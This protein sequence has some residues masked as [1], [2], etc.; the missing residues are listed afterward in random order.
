VKFAEDSFP[1]WFA[2]QGTGGGHA[3]RGDLAAR[4]RKL[5]NDGCDDPI[6]RFLTAHFE[7]AAGSSKAAAAGEFRQALGQLEKQTNYPRAVT[8]LVA[9]YLFGALD[10]PE[11]ALDKKTLGWTRAAL[12]EG[13]CDG[14]DDALFVEDAFAG[15]ALLDRNC[16]SM[17]DIVND[18]KNLP[19]RARRTILGRIE[20]RRARHAR[21]AA[22]DTVNEESSKGFGPGLDA[23]RDE[24]LSAWKLRPDQ[25][26]AATEMIKVVA[27]GAA[28]PRES[29]RLWFDRAVKA[30]FDYMPAYSAYLW[31]LRQ[32]WG[33]GNEEIL[34]FGHACAATKRYDTGVPHF[35]F[36]VIDDIGDGDDGRGTYSIPSVADDVIAVHKGTIAT[37]RPG[38]DLNYCISNLVLDAWACRRFDEALKALGQLPNRT[39]H[40]SITDRFAQFRTTRMIVLGEIPV[41]NSPAKD[42]YTKGRELEKS[43]RYP[44]AIGK[45]AAAQRKCGGDPD[46]TKMLEY[47]V[48]KDTTRVEFEKGQWMDISPRTRDYSDWALSP[49]AEWTVPEDGVLQFTGRDSTAISDW[50][51][52]VGENYEVRA[53][54]EFMNPPNTPRNF[55]I[56]LGFSFAQPNQTVTCQFWAA[57]PPKAELMVLGNGFYDFEN[58]KHQ[59]RLET[60]NDLHVKCWQGR[61]S[62]YL[63]GKTVFEKLDPRGGNPSHREGHVGFG[64]F[65][66]S[67]EQTVR[68]TNIAVRKLSAE[69]VTTGADEAK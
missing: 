66:L 63:N 7:R 46:A 47:L 27:Q 18:A 14:A 43:G 68:L 4:G 9:L 52:P 60:K 2:A 53:T 55:A 62:L 19:E 34:A 3:P 29:L 67:P 32:H 20:T 12:E 50:S 6:V 57:K 40:S 17:E 61:I 58:P 48:K 38:E 28:A 8:R 64:G 45:F 15:A 51:R 30:R 24:L 59:V 31:A 25:P 21:G 5:L 36:N 26:Y 42:D 37:A 33:G 11:P 22:A 23:A 49:R 39:L 16:D 35:L 54:F 13:S 56:A 1:A 41:F 69:P 65:K 10:R 44:E